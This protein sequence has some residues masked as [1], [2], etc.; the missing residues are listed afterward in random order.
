MTVFRLTTVDGACGPY[1]VLTPAG[2]DEQ[3]NAK[4]IPAVFDASLREQLIAEM[5]A[6]NWYRVFA[7]DDMLYQ[8]VCVRDEKGDELQS[9]SDWIHR[10]VGPV[11][12]REEYERLSRG[13]RRGLSLTIEQALNCD[14]P[15][16]PAF[17]ASTTL[18]LTLTETPHPYTVEIFAET[19]DR[20]IPA[21]WWAAVNRL[22]AP[23]PL[24]PLFTSLGD[25]AY[26]TPEE[27]TAIRAWAEAIAGWDNELW[28][29]EVSRYGMKHFARC[30]LT[31]G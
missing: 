31:G 6:G 13:E 30:E 28:F 5:F 8:R 7:D 25:V 4:R 21:D 3:S 20:H 11:V 22:I 18:E 17:E 24:G 23:D 14:S 9:V 2:G 1:I 29:Y 19:E 15:P 27:A 26:V 12:R 16:R 10:V